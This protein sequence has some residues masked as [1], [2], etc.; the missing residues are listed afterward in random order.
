MMKKS[1]SYKGRSMPNQGHT[2]TFRKNLS[3]EIKSRKKKKNI[4]TF[5]Q[6][7]TLFIMGEPRMFRP[8]DSRYNDPLNPWADIQE[9]I[10]YKAAAVYVETYSVHG[11]SSSTVWMMER[12]RD[13]GELNCNR[14]WREIGLCGIVHSSATNESKGRMQQWPGKKL[15]KKEETVKT[16]AALLLPISL[17][18]YVGGGIMY[19]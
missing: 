18:I 6:E 1:A 8:Y 14:L 13:P 17:C 3:R 11:T 16:A 19:V 7:E 4:Y 5:F 2:H 15:T 9:C 12:K 10:Y